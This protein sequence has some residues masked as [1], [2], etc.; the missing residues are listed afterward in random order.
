MRR[1]WPI[2]SRIR[3]DARLNTQNIPIKFPRLHARDSH[4][5]TGVDIASQGML[6]YEPIWERLVAW[7]QTLLFMYVDRRRT[8]LFGTHAQQYPRF[9]PFAVDGGFC[10]KGDRLHI[11]GDGVS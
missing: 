8:Q 1:P 2:K 6:R 9:R 5:E 4:S 11:R 3:L 7:C 10:S